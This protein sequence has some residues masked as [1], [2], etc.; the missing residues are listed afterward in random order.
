MA[1]DAL[2]VGGDGLCGEHLRHWRRAGRPAGAAFVTWRAQR[3]EA[4]PQTRLVDL[5]GLPDVLRAEFLVG[6]SV[7][8]ARH[9]RTP[10]GDLRRVVAIIRDRA[11]TSISQL[12]AASIRTPTVRRFVVWAQDWLRLAFADP[13]VE[14][15]KDVWDMRVFGKPQAYR[16]DFTQITQPWLRELAKQWAREKAPLVHAAATRRAVTSIAEL[17][18]S[19]RRRDD[20]GDDAAALGRADISLFLA[21]TARAQSAGRMSAHKR[22]R[23]IADVSYFLRQARDLGLGAPGQPVLG[24]AA[25]FSLSRD[26][27][28]R[29]ARKVQRPAARALPDTVVAQLLDEAALGLLERMHGS[30]V[31][32]AI[33][34]LADTGRRPNEICILAWDCLDYDAQIDDNGAEPEAR[35]AH[36]RHAQGR[37]HRL[38]AADRSGDRRADRHPE[39]PR[40]RALPRHAR[41]RAAAVSAPPAQPAR[42]HADEPD[43]PRT[44][45]AALGHRATRAA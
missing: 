41:A 43:G 16:V 9:R 40:A 31:R 42:D 22:G 38:P 8:I 27:V 26:D 4:L 10:I 2:A 20:D 37:A 35:G 11:P 12:D 5:G 14:W 21:R 34:V 39:A 44:G 15:R 33:E 25:A 17:S 32:L 13:D 18:R 30:W 7:A 23:L 45:D 24:L 28:R 36:P 19:L 3:D 6:L 29:V 1:C